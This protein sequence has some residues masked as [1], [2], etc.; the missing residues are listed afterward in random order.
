MNSNANKKIFFFILFVLGTFILLEFPLDPDFGWHLVS[1]RIIAETGSVPSHN[2]FSYTFQNYYWANS[3]WLVQVLMHLFFSFGGSFLISLVFSLIIS[4]SFTYIFYIMSSYPT[5]ISSFVLV[6]YFLLL[7]LF[8]VSVRPLGFST[9]LM[10]LIMFLIFYKQKYFF[11]TPLIF[12]LWANVHADF[13]LG[14]F[15]FGTYVLFDSYAFWKKGNFSKLNVF[16]LLFVFLGVLLTFINPYGINLWLTLLKET[17]PFQFTYIGEWTPLSF[18]KDL[19]LI[20]LY[21]MISICVFY[22]FYRKKGVQNTWY[23]LISVFFALLALRS[24]YFIRLFL[25]ISVFSLLDMFYFA[26][27]LLA[28]RLGVYFAKK[29][30]FVIK[31]FFGFLF[32]YGIFN[33]SDVLAGSKDLRVWAAKKDYPY[34]AVTYLK[35]VPLTG[36]MYNNYQW[37][38][39]LIWQLPTH[40]TFIDGRMPSWRTETGESVFEDYINLETSPKDNLDLLEKYN[41]DWIIHTPNSSLVAYLRTSKNWETVYLDDVS[42]ILVKKY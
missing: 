22:N 17:H 37:G 20:V 42:I 40:K 33:Y 21:L 5:Y 32:L 31:F 36:N 23:L 2:L 8:N 9:V 7:S 25:V 14:L 29:L 12:L 26:H 1:G 39:F 34:N 19:V 13:L 4:A 10:V 16:N 41:I 27:N 15:V 11:L 28:R 24:Q 18:S 35:E 3:Y 30:S 6:L 38:G